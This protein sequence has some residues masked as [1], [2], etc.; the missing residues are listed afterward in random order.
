M[1][2]SECV[3]AQD[4]EEVTKAP[5]L[6]SNGGLSLN[7]IST[8]YPGDTMGRSQ[9][10]TYYLAG[11]LNFNF[12]SVV[13]VPMSFAYTNNTLTKEGALPFNRFS[14]APSYK[15]VKLYL[16]YSSMTFSPYTLAGR[17]IFGSGAELTFEN[18]LK[19]SA[20][21]GRLQKEVF[22]DSNLVQPAYKRLGGGFKAEYTNQYADVAVNV[23]KAKDVINPRFFSND[24][25]TVIAPMD[26]IS[27]SVLLNV[28]MID[29]LKLNVEYAVSAINSDISK[30]DSVPSSFKDNFIE[31][32]GDLA[33]HH[34]VKASVIETTS[35][36]QIGASYERVNPNYNTLGAYYM[37]NDYQNIT[38]N[39]STSI[40]QWLNFAIDAGYQRDNLSGQKMN[41][42]KRFIVS[43]N[44]S[45]AINSR[46]SVGASYSNIQSFVHIN[47]IYNQ[48]T[49]TNQFQ[50]LDT[51]SF[52]QLNLTV[53]GNANYILKSSKENRQSINGAFS[54]QEASEQQKSQKKYSG[55]TIYNSVLS[56]QYALIPRKF[57]ASTSVNYN[58]NQMP[59]GFMGVASFSLS[60]QKALFEQFKIAFIGTYSRSFNDTINLARILNLRLTAGITY[61]KRHNFNF[62]VARVYNKGI[63][64]SMTQYSANLT[65]SYI[66]DFNLQRKDKKYKYEGN[67]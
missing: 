54:Y 7:Q 46:L 55:S 18:G 67:F 8:V 25:D 37:A 64:K 15:W 30:K 14:I 45:S 24:I 23:F 50:N 19:F 39:F 56:Y 26:N 40:K 53:S 36:G 42:S 22:P 65:Y 16:G 4:I 21:Y 5:A 1:F 52:S 48:V 41:S 38:A 20:I 10:Y 59:S 32:H 57:N 31:Q 9:P 13:N 44:A 12:F 60:L 61:Q 34:A 62:S 49:S 11:N 47:D 51:M 33:L 63:I 43:T 28:K 29:N 66:F 27:G 58:H 3:I 6:M 35:I 17:E 2:A